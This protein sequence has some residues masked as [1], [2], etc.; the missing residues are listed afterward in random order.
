MHELS[1]PPA[2]VAAGGALLPFAIGVFATLVLGVDAGCSGA[3]A[4]DLFGERGSGA[5]A[6]AGEPIPGLRDAASTEASVP[7]A[8]ACPPAGRCVV[9]SQ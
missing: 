4:N 5:S 1:S 2:T 7:V 9:P 3:K 6:D 8:V